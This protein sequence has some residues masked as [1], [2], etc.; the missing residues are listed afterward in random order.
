MITYTFQFNTHEGCSKEPY[1]YWSVDTT[2]TDYRHKCRI[3]GYFHSPLP[4]NT[5]L[6][7]F[8]TVT[9]LRDFGAVKDNISVCVSKKCPTKASSLEHIIVIEGAIPPHP[10]GWGLLAQV[11]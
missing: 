3:T 1:S 5:G 10:E 4:T 7:Y 9:E 6:Q 2:T 8:G 11:R